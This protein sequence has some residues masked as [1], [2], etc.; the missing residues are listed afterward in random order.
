MNYKKDALVRIVRFQASDARRARVLLRP[1]E[2]RKAKLFRMLARQQ[3]R[4]RSGEVGGQRVAIRSD[5][6]G[7][8]RQRILDRNNAARA[9]ELRDSG[10]AVVD[11]RWCKVLAR[12]L[13]CEMPYRNE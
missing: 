5:A 10:H 1:E 11:D 6:N 12:L 7:L 2:P 13:R 3:Q 8:A 9:V 4:E